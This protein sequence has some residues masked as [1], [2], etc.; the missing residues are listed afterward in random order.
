MILGREVSAAIVEIE[1]RLKR[2]ASAL[3]RVVRSKDGEYEMSKTKHFPASS[4]RD[5]G[6]KGSG[7]PK[8]GGFS[9]GGPGPRDGGFTGGG[10]GP[11]P[12]LTQQVGSK[13]GSPGKGNGA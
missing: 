10:P 6:F 4:P 3:S 1:F 11:K 5:S 7:R 9:G 8:D 13:H 2:P 12:P